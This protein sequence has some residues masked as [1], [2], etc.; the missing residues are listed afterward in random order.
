[1]RSPLLSHGLDDEFYHDPDRAASAAAARLAPPSSLGGFSGG[2]RDRR[3]VSYDEA[4]SPAW[5]AASRQGTVLSSIFSLV[6]TIMG[7]GVLS[8][9]YAFREAGLVWGVVLLGF[10]ALAS[11]Y[12]AFALVA[13]SR[14]SGAHTYEDVA[15]LA[16]GAQGRLYTMVLVIL[17][18]YLALVAYSILLLDLVVPA[19]LHFGPAALLPSNPD[20][21]GATT[22]LLK[23]L[24]GGSLE[25]CI[26]PFAFV[27]EF[28][29][30]KFL[31]VLAVGNVALVAAAVV[32]HATRCLAHGAPWL[33]AN[34]GGGG[35][36]YMYSNATLHDAAFNA[37]RSG[38]G[39]AEAVDPRDG[40][41]AVLLWPAGGGRAVVQAAPVF[42]CTFMCHFNVL[43]VHA[44]LQRPTR[45]RVHCMVH[46]TI[47]VAALLYLVVGVSGFAFT[48]CR[49][50]ATT[51]D[52][53]LTEYTNDDVVANVGRAGISCTLLL[54]LPL[55]LSPCRDTL[56]RLLREWGW[57]DPPIAAADLARHT[58]AQ[59]RH[60]NALVLARHND[61][62]DT[63][64]SLPLLSPA[65]G[66]VVGD[67]G[68]GGHAAGVGA[69]GLLAFP[70]PAAASLERGGRALSSPSLSAAVQSAAAS[71]RA[72]GS[73][74][75]SEGE[76]VGG[77]SDTGAGG[78]G[79][80]H[81]GRSRARSVS[82]GFGGFAREAALAR[83][84][85]ERMW[86]PS[87]GDREPPGGGSSGGESP[88]PASTPR[89]PRRAF[90]ACTLAVY[91]SQ[92]LLAVVI[93]SVSVIWGVLGS[94]GALAVA[95]TIPAASYLQV[96]SPPLVAAR[97]RGRRAAATAMVYGSL[98]LALL[99]TT[100]TVYNLAVAPA[101]S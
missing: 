42:V 80:G 52:N 5:A 56:L 17:L 76:W 27:D 37:S 95:F 86:R 91:A 101:A 15:H 66:G 28:S 10:V 62:L 23:L 79:G 98:A 64:A 16:F 53:I 48:A 60:P 1:M 67:G 99:C 46:S 20:A 75:F 78:G 55:I 71:R 18:C 19:F 12:S 4:F 100:N 36:A 96:T 45:G 89:A 68:G 47:G 2:H 11:D 49:G 61:A 6:S 97:K 7:G 82:G 39:D 59:A 43:P 8:L 41:W 40:L 34:D 3:S 38:Y 83:A 9:P 54:A 65:S 33:D 69:V 21:P 22:Y 14:R 58:Q 57:P 26:L 74:G 13:C 44:E 81:D 24:L 72:S 73:G 87:A 51:A 70:A 35:G 32:A 29:R 84:E 90:V 93:P 31:S 30:L 85:A 25:L 63:R 92:F 50:Q 88:G 94:T 77:A